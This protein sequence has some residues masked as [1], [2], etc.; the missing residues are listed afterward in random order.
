[1]ILQGNGNLLQGEC[2][3]GFCAMTMPLHMMR[4]EF[5]S[6]WPR[7]G[8]SSLLLSKIKKIL[9]GQRFGDNRDIRRNVTLLRGIQENY[10]QDCYRQ[11]RHRLTKCTASQGEHFEG[12]SSR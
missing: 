6:Y 7:N 3:S 9:K 11:W 5:A 8:Y 4:L 12:N 10:F 2:P 1:M